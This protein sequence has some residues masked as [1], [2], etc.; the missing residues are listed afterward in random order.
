LIHF[1]KKKP[2]KKKEK[3]AIN[4]IHR[5]ILS[6][7]DKKDTSGFELAIFSSPVHHSVTMLSE[8]LVEDELYFILPICENTYPCRKIIIR[9]R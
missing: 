9:S 8:M 5:E 2:K 6:H 1:H 3:S 7:M 4:E